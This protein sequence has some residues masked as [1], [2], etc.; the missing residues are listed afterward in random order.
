VPPLA[1]AAAVGG[2]W[3]V[4]VVTPGPNF[5]AAARIAAG[6]DRRAGLAAVLGIGA[7]TLL[8]GLAG[9]LGVR[10]MFALAPWLFGVLKL[11]GAVYLVAMGGRIIAAS[12]KPVSGPTAAPSRR[13]AVWLGFLTSV[14]NPKSALFVAALFA[15]VLPPDAPLWVGL[16]AAAEMV[17]ISLGWYG[18]VVLLLSTRAASAA[19]L[20]GR[21]WIDRLAGAVFAAF[22]ARLLLE[23]A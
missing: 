9:C 16:S 8:W 17:A 5:L 19:Y 23:R 6:R 1:F 20:R 7:G 22:G 3:T 10:A 12:F 13:S 11:L 14:S 15:S 18:L 2:L 21:R 4:A